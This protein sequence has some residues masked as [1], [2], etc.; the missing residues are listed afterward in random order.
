MFPAISF[1]SRHPD[2]LSNIVILSIAATIAQ[3]FISYTIKTF[4]ALLFATVM[5]TR[6]F[7]SILLSCFMF[8]HPLSLGQMAATVMIFGTLYYKNLSAGG[9]D[10]KGAPK[11]GAPESVPLKSDIESGEPSV[12]R[13]FVS[14]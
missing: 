12:L 6:Q 8:F 2:C 1:L 5:T 9:G 3:L 14:K 13:D 10:K 4:G 7:L 11:A